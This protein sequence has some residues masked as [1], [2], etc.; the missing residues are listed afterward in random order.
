[1]LLGQTESFDQLLD[2]CAKLEDR[3]NEL[4]RGHKLRP[5]SRMPPLGS[6]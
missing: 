5:S 2:E 1:M 6:G 3:M 4:M